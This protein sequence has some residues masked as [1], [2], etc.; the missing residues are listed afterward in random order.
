MNK[1]K[2]FSKESEAYSNYLLSKKITD[3]AWD[4]L[5][6]V[7]SNDK[8]FGFTNLQQ[9]LGEF[10]W[11]FGLFIYSVFNILRSLTAINKERGYILLHTT[12]L[13]ITIFYLF[14]IFQP[15]QDLS[16][17]SYYLM[18]ILTG[19]VISCSIY[20]MSKYKFTDNGKLKDIIKSLFDFIIVDVNDRELIKEDKKEYYEKKY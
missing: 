9:F 4:E 14:W 2:E 17:F 10:G 13:S 8:V 6:K 15:F 3:K 5:K 1:L 12:I 18:S 19:V 16:K 20:L 11:V 7:K